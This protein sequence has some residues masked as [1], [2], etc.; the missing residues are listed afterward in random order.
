MYVS[1][2]SRWSRQVTLPS[3]FADHAV[4]LAPHTC[5]VDMIS[6]EKNYSG[7]IDPHRKET[8]LRLHQSL[9]SQAGNISL[10]A[11]VFYA[12]TRQC[13]YHC[14]FH[15]KSC[16]CR[17]LNSMGCGTFFFI[18][19]TADVTGTQN[20]CHSSVQCPLELENMLT[21][22]HYEWIS[23]A[24]GEETDRNRGCATW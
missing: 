24:S 9:P 16:C 11:N 21:C 17:T 8:E 18:Y 3:R 6:V 4:K 13:R 1:Q 19:L 7:K 23:S 10:Q 22:R 15:P 12:D 20:Y 14:L 2:N 5:S